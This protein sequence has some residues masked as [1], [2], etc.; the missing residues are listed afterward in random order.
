[1]LEARFGGRD[2]GTGRHAKDANAEAHAM[3]QRG[4][5]LEAWQTRG[6]KMLTDRYKQA[7]QFAAT[8][9]DGHLRKGTQVAYLSHLMS[10]SALVMENGGSEDEAIAALLH[11]SIEDRGNDYESPFQVEPRHGREALKRDIELQFGADVLALV[12]HC[13][14]DEYL[15]AGRPTNK[16]TPEEWRVRKAAYHES[17]RNKADVAP[18][19]VSCADKLHNAR[20]ILADYEVEGEKLWQRFNVAS[21]QEQLWYYE[22]LADAFVERSLLLGD[23]GLQR[24]AR[25]LAATV[26][27]IARHQPA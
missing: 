9:H 26:E 2:A 20:A 10:V 21:K 27:A 13:T 7:M 8:V 16:G 14:D 18:L 25:Q 22:G 12:K 6:G 1:M 24:L 17:L 23:D 5:S 15:P 3:S 4:F 11:D 19:R